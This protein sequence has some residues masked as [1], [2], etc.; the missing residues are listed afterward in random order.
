MSKETYPMKR[1]LDGVYLRVERDGRWL[2]LCLTDLTEA[3]RERV[4]E[5]RSPEWL[6]DLALIMARTL[7]EMGDQLDVVGVAGEVA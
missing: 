7:R 4:T 6:R 2:S 5:G 1:D 3:E